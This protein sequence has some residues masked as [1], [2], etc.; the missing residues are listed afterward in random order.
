MN[1]DNPKIY[2]LGYLYDVLGDDPES[3]AELINT[4]LTYTPKDLAELN[5]AYQN[6]DF[7][8][9]A[10]IAH[11]LKSSVATLKIATLK[12]TFQEIDK[13][14]KV[15]ER[16]EDLPAIMEKINTILEEAMRQ[17]REDFSNK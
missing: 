14:Y 2:D 3:I 4:F 11:K 12:D 10:A 13:P 15:L 5:Q 8:Q 6:E 16:K 7:N 9:L 1:P 17:L